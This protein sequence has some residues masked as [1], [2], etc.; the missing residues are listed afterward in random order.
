DKF[1][2]EAG[3]DYVYV[4]DA[5]GNEVARYDGAPRRLPVTSPCL[6]GASG[7]VQLVTDP[8]V[9]AYGFDARVVSC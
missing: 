7:S 8:A 6:S 5:A 2:T 4:K 3:Y 1:E 9:T